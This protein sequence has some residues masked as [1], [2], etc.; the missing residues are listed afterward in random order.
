VTE[1]TVRFIADSI[2]ILPIPVILVLGGISIVSMRLEMLSA[3][4]SLPVNLLLT[5]AFANYHAA[6]AAG[7]RRAGQPCNLLKIKLSA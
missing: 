1:H 5:H 3:A 7:L 4:G 6:D 2:F